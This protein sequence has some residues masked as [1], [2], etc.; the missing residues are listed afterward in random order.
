MRVTLVFGVVFGVSCVTLR[1]HRRIASR[2]RFF[3]ARVYSG[4]KRRD[5]NIQAMRN[6]AGAVFAGTHQDESAYGKKPE[7]GIIRGMRQNPL[8]L[9]RARDKEK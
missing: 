3:C 5:A 6:P 2:P 7:R 1:L 9:P 8:L 4:E